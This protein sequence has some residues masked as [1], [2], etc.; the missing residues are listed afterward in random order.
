MKPT[1]II[2]IKRIMSNN[3]ILAE[4]LEM[5]DSDLVFENL[6]E[7]NVSNMKWLD[8][9]LKCLRDYLLTQLN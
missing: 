1:D 9:K 8:D 7:E 6:Q 3:N 2:K 5:S 4:D